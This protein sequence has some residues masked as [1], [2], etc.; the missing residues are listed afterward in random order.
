MKGQHDIFFI[1]ASQG[2]EGFGML[3]S[4]LLQKL[5]VAA[6]SID[7]DG[8]GEEYTEFLAPFLIFFNDFHINAHQQELACQVVGAASAP[9]D[10]CVFH[11]FGFK[12][13]FFQESTDMFAGGYDGNNISFFDPEI[14]AW[15]GYFP[16]AF[17]GAD[18]YVIGDVS[19][20]IGDGH[21]IQ[22]I[23]FRYFEFNDLC[24]SI[25]E[26]S[27]LQCGGQEQDAGD[28]TGGLQFWVD[29]HGESQPCTEITYLLAVVRGADPGNGVAVVPYLFGDGAAEQVQ[30]IRGGNGD[31][32]I[33]LLNTSLHLSAV[34]GTVSS[35]SHDIIKIC[36]F[37]YLGGILVDDRDV[38]PFS[39][40]LL[41]K[42]SPNFPAAHNDYMQPSGNGLLY[43]RHNFLH[44]MHIAYCFHNS[45]TIV[46]THFAKICYTI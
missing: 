38:V 17:H 8:L 27:D 30:L 7:N 40:K 31:D 37:L 46:I 23:F 13:D 15:D 34:A 44:L 14:T 25:G 42:C 43:H 39:A 9:H 10:H 2:N 20:Q 5:L 1:D 35:D 19:A 6:V 12:S 11:L 16:A 22:R 36:D 45:V 32:K 3:D 21:A 41:Y 33:C 29:H 18:Q 4:L 26:G 24:L 28:L